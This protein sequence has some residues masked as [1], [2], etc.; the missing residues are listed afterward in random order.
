MRQINSYERHHISRSTA[1]ENIFKSSAAAGYPLATLAASITLPP[2]IAITA[3]TPSLH[4]ISPAFS[5]S[6]THGLGEILS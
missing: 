2:P 6:E 1:S 3:S 4:N 5:A